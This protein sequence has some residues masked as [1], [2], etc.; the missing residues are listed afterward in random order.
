MNLQITDGLT[1][2]KGRCRMLTMAEPCHC[3]TQLGQIGVRKRLWTAG[4]EQVIVPEG[5]HLFCRPYR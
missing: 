5:T 1:E 2:G 4:M 3:Q